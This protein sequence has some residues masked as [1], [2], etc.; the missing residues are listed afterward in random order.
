MLSTFDHRAQ[1]AVIPGQQTLPS[2]RRAKVGQICD[3][4]STGAN[5]MPL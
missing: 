4:N 2:Q 1:T 5:G 3:S